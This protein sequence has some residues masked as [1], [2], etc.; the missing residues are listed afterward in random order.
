M[1]PRPED[2]FTGFNPQV[3]TTFNLSHKHSGIQGD[4]QQIKS[5]NLDNTAPFPAGGEPI[6][7]DSAGNWWRISV[8]SFTD[9]ETQQILGRL[10][11]TLVP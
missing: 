8:E 9:P 11:V 7:Q 2:K 10:V 4:G 1:S 6:Y 3:G 5:A